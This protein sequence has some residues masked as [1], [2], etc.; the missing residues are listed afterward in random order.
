MMIPSDDEHENGHDDSNDSDDVD[1]DDDD[2][3]GLLFLFPYLLPIQYL[4]KPTPGPHQPAHL[5]DVQS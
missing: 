3:D 1:D 2:D 5:G 4:S